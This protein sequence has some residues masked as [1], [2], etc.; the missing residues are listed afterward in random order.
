MKKLIGFACILLS[1][2]AQAQNQVYQAGD[3]IIVAKS[4]GTGAYG[5]PSSEVLFGVESG[6]ILMDWRG[7]RIFFLTPA[8]FLSSS[9]SA[10]GVTADAA[11][12]AFKAT[13]PTFSGGGG[14]GGGGSFTPATFGSGPPVATSYTTNAGTISTTGTLYMLIQNIGS[15]TATV[16]YAGVTTNLEAKEQY[17]YV[18]NYDRTSNK[19]SPFAALSINATGTTVVVWKTPTQ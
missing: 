9:G 5:Y 18:A 2:A 3:K 7:T 6:K 14:G 16:T 12:T 11:F 1:L 8:Q 17:E 15:T 13:W 4:D 19:Y 10:W